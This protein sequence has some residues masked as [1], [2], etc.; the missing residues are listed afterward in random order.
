MPELRLWSLEEV[1]VEV[2]VQCNLLD[3]CI[4]EEP[5]YSTEL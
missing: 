3:M 2:E 1:D 4:S 5:V